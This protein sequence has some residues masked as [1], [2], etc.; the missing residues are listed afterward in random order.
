MVSRDLG[1]GFRAVP[2]NAVTLNGMALSQ[3]NTMR[4]PYDG[5]WHVIAPNGR[6]LDN[7]YGRPYVYR[8]IEEAKENVKELVKL[9]D[10]STC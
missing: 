6:A 1:N 9:G 4:E 7:E 5:E 10:Y 2:R 3:L 8:T